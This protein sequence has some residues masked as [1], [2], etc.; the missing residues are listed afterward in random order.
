MRHELRDARLALSAAGAVGLA[1]VS[2]NALPGLTTIPPVRRTLTPSLSGIGDPGHVALSFDDGP[3]PASTP[4]F[5]RVLDDLGW[6]ATFFMLG[7]MVRS[8]PGLAGEVAAAGHEVALHGDL[9]HSHLLRGPRWV[10]DDTKRA[11]GALRAATG[12]DPRWFRPPY[13]AISAGTILSARTAGLRLVLWSA[14]GRDWRP[15]ATARS[16]AAE[17]AGAMR[18]GAT[19]LLHDSDCTSAACSWKAALGALPLLAETCAAA[20]WKVGTV[21]EHSVA[22][23]P[24]RAC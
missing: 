23:A 14:W 15:Q 11:A 8:A 1:A 18:P 13:G 20:G 3:D 22:A 5:L 19:V 6:K 10:L 7:S 9:H 16:V 21:S 12:A 4:A 2:L 17:L 24:P